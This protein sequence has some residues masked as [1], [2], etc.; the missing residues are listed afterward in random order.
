MRLF[1]T[2]VIIFSFNFFAKAQENTDSLENAFNPESK[3]AFFLPNKTIIFKTKDSINPE[4]EVINGKELVFKYE[5]RSKE[6]LMISDDEF[7]ERLF[8]K[9]LPKG[10]QFIYKLN[11]FKK[12]HL[13]YSQSCFCLDAGNYVIQKGS[14]VGKK[15]N[16]TTWDV[17][18][19]FSYVARNSKTLVNKTYRLKYKIAEKDDN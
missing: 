14:I 15:V 3:K 10:N 2:I 9:V 5:F 17:Q 6:Y 12:S 11:N 8:F 7:V 4:F 18:V 13:L 1:I 16:K 19:K